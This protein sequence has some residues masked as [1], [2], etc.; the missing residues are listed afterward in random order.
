MCQLE[1][2]RFCLA[3]CA[4]DAT[5][6]P[7]VRIEQNATRVQLRNDALHRHVNVPPTAPKVR[8]RQPNA[9]GRLDV[10]DVGETDDI[11]ADGEAGNG[12]GNCAGDAL[13]GIIV[14]ILFI[15][16]NGSVN[17][18]PNAV[19]TSAQPSGTTDN[20]SKPMQIGMLSDVNAAW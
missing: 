8:T 20:V 2:F 7:N 3:V 10:V 19:T 6:D 18:L 11:A 16:S 9:G 12:E 4:V 5:L 17:S 15:Q 1:R 14:V 13:V